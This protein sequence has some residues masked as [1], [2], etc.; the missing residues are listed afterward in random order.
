MQRS[1]SASHRALT[2]NSSSLMRAYNQRTTRQSS[3]PIQRQ[4]HWGFRSLRPMSPL[5]A[6]QLMS[7]KDVSVGMHTHAGHIHNDVHA[8]MH[9]C[10]HTH[11]HIHRLYKFI[12]L[13]TCTYTCMH[14]HVHVHTACC[15][16]ARHIFIDCRITRVQSPPRSSYTLLLKRVCFYRYMY[17][18]MYMYTHSNVHVLYVALTI[19]VNIGNPV[20]LLT[21][22][23]GRLHVHIHACTCISIL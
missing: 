13:C 11:R 4:H 6:P 8:C 20:G 9:A 7:L 3:A 10:M 22:F 19:K 2:R 21:L 23:I 14:V 5:N 15:S 12:G 17:M 1:A 16:C 18:Y